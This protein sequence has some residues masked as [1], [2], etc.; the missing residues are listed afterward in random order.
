MKPID[1]VPVVG[2]MGHRPTFRHPFRSFRP[3]SE[4][5]P[6]SLREIG[7]VKGMLQTGNF[8][9]KRL[10]SISKKEVP[11]V[12]YSGYLKSVKAENMFGQTY[13]DLAS[14]SVYS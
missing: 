11:V 10:G 6:V 14:R 9:S 5:K 13:N 2:Y 7:D 8:D 3:P 12:G 1:R 4:P